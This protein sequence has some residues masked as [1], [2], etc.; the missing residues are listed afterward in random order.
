MIL[1]LAPLVYCDTLS[2]TFSGSL[3]GQLLGAFSPGQ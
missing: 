2:G 3:S 1:S